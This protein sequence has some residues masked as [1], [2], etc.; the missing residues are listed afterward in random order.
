M[1]RICVIGPPGSGKTPLARELAR[2][3]GIRYIDFDATVLLPHWERVPREQRM[4]LFEPLT[5]DGDWGT[6]GH[7]RSGREWEQLLLSRADTVIW[8]DLPRW[9]TM[10]SVVFRTLR[11][12]VTRRAAFGEN[13]ESIS[14]L[15]SPEHSIVLGWTM[16]QPLRNEYTRLFSDPANREKRLLRLTSR[17][18]LGRW[19]ETVGR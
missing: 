2:R 19:L 7:L 9:R 10:A 8:L 6:D 3:Q 15:W 17:H 18:S 11:N 12:T 5:R 14:M 13:V 16:Y 1:G 4:A